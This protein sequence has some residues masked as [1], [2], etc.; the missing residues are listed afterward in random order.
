MSPGFSFSAKPSYTA[1]ITPAQY[2]PQPVC[3]AVGV[4]RVTTRH[5]MLAGTEMTEPVCLTSALELD[6]SQTTILNSVRSV[7]AQFDDDYWLQLDRT[8]EFPHAFYDEMAKGGWLGIAMP[9]E[10]GGAG[11][12]IFE[13]A[14]IMHTVA[15]SPGGMSAASAIHINIFGPHPIVVHGTEDQTREWL[16]ELIQGRSKC[17]FGVT[18]P[19]SGL[20][21][22]SIQ[23]FAQP[24]DD[25]YIVYRSENMDV[26]GTAC[27]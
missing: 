24:D 7:V 6:T 3:V 10:V 5:R 22:G 9:E 13:A 1:L 20:E 16:P 14:L 18:E 26:Y 25:G 2:S 8:G 27:R 21:T 4:Y 23:T 19:D 12:G 11:L 17:C 15:N